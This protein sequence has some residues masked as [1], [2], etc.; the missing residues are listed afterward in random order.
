MTELDFRN[1]RLI[2]LG[3]LSVTSKEAADCMKMMLHDAKELAGVYHG[4]NRSAK[5][6]AGWPDE[7]KFASSN[8]RSFI[9]AVIEGYAA[10]L[11]KPNVAEDDKR[12][13]YIARLVWERVSKDGSKEPDNRMQLRPNTQQFVGDPFENRK[14]ADQF[15]VHAH[16]RA[17][18][19]NS[20]A[21]RH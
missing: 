16:G 1:Q 14:I 11:G 17:R 6:R 15:G 5:F 18:F 2:D 4:Q 12:R 10:L 3:A 9:Q 20:V 7:R 13:M 8:W 19:L 21:T